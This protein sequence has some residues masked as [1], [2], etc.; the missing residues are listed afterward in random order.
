M[1]G[2]PEHKVWEGIF[3]RCHNPNSRFFAYY[4]GRGIT[5]SDDWRRFEN[6]L[7]DMGRRPTPLHTLDRID[8]NGNYCWENCRWATRREQQRNTRHNRLITFNG[9]TMLA[10]DWDK[11]A[12]RKQGTITSRIS[13][14]YPI[15]RI[16]QAAFDS[17]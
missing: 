8:P 9:V 4:G 5:V 15:S 12:G 14:G 7:V 10:C 3:Q 16:L 17:M 1:S 11:A 13:G 6:F 2:V